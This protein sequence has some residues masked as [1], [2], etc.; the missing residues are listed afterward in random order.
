MPNVRLWCASTAATSAPGGRSR[1]A[2]STGFVSPAVTTAK[3][4]CGGCA[5]P[6]GGVRRKWL[7]HRPTYES[8]RVLPVLKLIWLASGQLGSEL[9]KVA[10]PVWLVHYERCQG[11]LDPDL[12]AKLRA[13]SPTQIDRLLRP[14]RLVRIRHT[15]AT[16][17]ASSA[18]IHAFGFS[19]G[20]LRSSSSASWLFHRHPTAAERG[21]VMTA[22]G[23][24]LER[25]PAG[26]DWDLQRDFE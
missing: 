10:L 16:M 14:V 1:P 8:G 24:G 20:F 15:R 19:L 18:G 4:P 3:P 6:R 13:I 9:L 11:L 17:R 25:M 23:A 2:S 22:V 26:H 21:L 5:G 12:P 7:G